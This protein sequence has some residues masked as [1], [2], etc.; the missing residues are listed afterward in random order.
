MRAITGADAVFYRTD[1]KRAASY[2]E[3]AKDQPVVS[4]IPFKVPGAVEERELGIPFAAGMDDITVDAA[5]FELRAGACTND[6]AINPTPFGPG[7]VV[8]DLGAEGRLTEIDLTDDSH[9]PPD[10]DTRLVLR[11]ATPNGSGY[12]AGT[13]LIA[14]P[15]FG[16][17]MFGMIL[18]GIDT[19][20]ARKLRFAPIAG[21]AF[22]LTWATGSNPTSLSQEPKP[23]GVKRVAVE[24][25]PRD[26]S[27]TLVADGT[28]VPVWN[29]PG[30]LLPG[31]LQSVSFV[32][33]A[34][35]LLRAQLATGAPPTLAVTL[36]FRSAAVS[37]LEITSPALAA[38]YSAEPAAQPLRAALRGSFERLELDA[39][40]TRAPSRTELR[41][42]AKYL[43]RML[44]DEYGPLTDA[45][46]VSG[47]RIDGERSVAARAPLAAR[48][49]R[50]PAALAS[51]R[52]QIA[53]L[54]PSEIALELRADAA[55][56][57]SA[58]LAA[59]VVRQLGA[60]FVGWVEIELPSPVPVDTPFVWIT[61]RA[62]KGE[63]V[64][65]CDAGATAAARVSATK[66]TGWTAAESLLL[67][68][69]QLFDSV[70]P[71]GEID[72]LLRTGSTLAQAWKLTR[73]GPKSV[74]YAAAG[75]TLPNAIR[76]LL[77]A[78]KGIGRATSRFDL[79][80]RAA[81]DLALA[82]ITLS[83]TA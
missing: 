3:M 16:G 50:Q 2:T 10:V 14:T 51:V 49:P 53:V 6:A 47:L 80:S 37:K 26:A 8:I 54:Q 27:V 22:I 12:T 60:P 75:A 77:A 39:P 30:P 38:T 33:A 40:A 45:P 11:A 20:A 58:L 1:A 83:Y 62:T 17:G 32:P 31:K 46:P 4:A 9:W 52:V 25:V 63:V 41:V 81:V 18:S 66:L 64:W 19:P 7:A 78:A 57:P 36:R 13:P 61:V 74:E 43:G 28:E 29:Q 42:T 34:E 68:R 72:I 79:F 69:V 48:A 55:G 70:P 24:G 65:C 73:T 44:N 15:G 71:P 35:R 82:D 5:Q 21:T 23:I 59:Q 67:P 76:A 56:G